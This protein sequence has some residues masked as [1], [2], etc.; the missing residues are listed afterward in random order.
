MQ[1]LRQ[2]TICERH[3]N[4]KAITWNPFRKKEEA[5]DPRSAGPKKTADPSEKKG[6]S[7]PEDEAGSGRRY[8]SAGSGGPQASAK[9]TKARLREKENAEYEAMQKGDI[10]HMP[11]AE[12]LPWRIYIRDYVDALSTLAN[13]IPV[14]FA[15]LIVSHVRHFFDAGT[16]GL[17]S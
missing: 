10:N 8:P 6:P 1:W 14:A 16:S 2:Y 11:K 15:I 7:Y 12:R 9:A 3:R 17:P 4:F 5:Q 13:V